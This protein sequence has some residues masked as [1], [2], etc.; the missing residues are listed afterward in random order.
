VLMSH[1]EDLRLG[2]SSDTLITPCVIR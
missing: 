2:S 1:R